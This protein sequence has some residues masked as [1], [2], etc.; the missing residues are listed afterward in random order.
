M[1]T[2]GQRNTLGLVG[3]MIVLFSGVDLL[4]VDYVLFETNVHL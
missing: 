3:L 1:A 4:N 2:G